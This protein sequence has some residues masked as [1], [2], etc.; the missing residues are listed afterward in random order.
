MTNEVTVTL[1]DPNS[2]YKYS[3]MELEIAQGRIMYRLNRYYKAKTL[4]LKR[5]YDKAIKENK[6]SVFYDKK[7]MP[8]SVVEAML[9]HWET[10]YY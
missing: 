10:T 8:I 6:D 5:A 7:N 2:V 9:D 1:N 3:I 4:L